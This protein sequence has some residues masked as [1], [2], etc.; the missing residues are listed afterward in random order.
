MSFAAADLKY[1]NYRTVSPGREARPE[2]PGE[3]LFDR[4]HGQDVL[5]LI[6]F[7]YMR[8]NWPGY[9]KGPGRKIEMLLRKYLPATVQTRGE[10]FE[11]ISAN[12]RI[13]WDRL[14]NG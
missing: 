2:T 7:C 4:Q 3:D 6:N 13:Y 8:W 11:W 9:T 12:W 14:P 10:A 5:D 1:K